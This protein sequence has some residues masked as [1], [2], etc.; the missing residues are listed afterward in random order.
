MT[1]RT[2]KK[3]VATAAKDVPADAPIWS[4]VEQLGLKLAL[5][6]AMLLNTCGAACESFN[7]MDEEQRDVYL[8]HCAGIAHAARNEAVCIMEAALD[9]SRAAAAT[10]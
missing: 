3:P 10:V 4:R 1:N 9:E 8:A 6:D 5:L 7:D 2:P